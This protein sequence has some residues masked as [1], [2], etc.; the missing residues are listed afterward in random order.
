M[1]IR[2]LNSLLQQKNT[3]KKP[4]T[5][6]YELSYSKFTLSLTIHLPHPQQKIGPVHTKIILKYVL[7][8]SKPAAHS[9]LES[10]ICGLVRL[11]GLRYNSGA[12]IT[13][14]HISSRNTLNSEIQR[15]Q[16]TLGGAHILRNSRWNLVM[17]IKLDAQTTI[18]WT[19]FCIRCL[20]M[21]ESF[22][23]FFSRMF[24]CLL[25]LSSSVHLYFKLHHSL[26]TRAHIGTGCSSASS[27]LNCP[28][29]TDSSPSAEGAACGS[30]AGVARIA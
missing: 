18:S 6:D 16:C 21:I 2:R 26:L 10:S 5:E 25:A 14:D 22:F 28:P 12:T 23:A 13:S 9:A 20:S 15:S 17:G 3:G 30:L 4:P 8:W 29:Q 19:I 27:P 7:G 11:L 1:F 24:C